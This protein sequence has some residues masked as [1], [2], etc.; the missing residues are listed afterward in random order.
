GGL[1]LPR[2]ELFSHFTTVSVLEPRTAILSTAMP[3]EPVHPTLGVV[4]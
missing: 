2:H 4:Q 1:H 3:A